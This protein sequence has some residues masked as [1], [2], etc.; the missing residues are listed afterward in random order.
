MFGAVK[1]KLR[2]ELGMEQMYQIAW[3][4]KSIQDF[5]NSE[6]RVPEMF[7]RDFDELA[8]PLSF[9]L[10][11]AYLPLVASADGMKKKKTSISGALETL[12]PNEVLFFFR[13]VLFAN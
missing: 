5:K 8:T 4:L 6:S 12:S 10:A 7:H 13:T 9:V 1:Q 11:G 3:T 2:L